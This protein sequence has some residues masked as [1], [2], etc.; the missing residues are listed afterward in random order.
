MCIDERLYKSVTVKPYHEDEEMVFAEGKIYY[1]EDG[2]IH[3]QLSWINSGYKAINTSHEEFKLYALKALKDSVIV[4][5][6]TEG[7]E[8]RYQVRYEYDDK[9]YDWRLSEEELYSLSEEYSVPLYSSL[10]C[11]VCDEEL[12][13]ENIALVRSCLIWIYAQ[14]EQWYS[15]D[16]E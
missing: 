2:Y 9:V 15:D 16:N 3:S 13:Y 4:S 7:D 6:T 10:Y 8:S 1:S 14:W 5:I 11:A 12:V